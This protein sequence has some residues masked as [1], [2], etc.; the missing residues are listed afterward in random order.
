[1]N[2]T[3]VQKPSS[4]E[5]KNSSINSSTIHFLRSPLVDNIG[6]FSEEDSYGQEYF[7]I[8]TNIDLDKLLMAQPDFVAYLEEKYPLRYTSPATSLAHHLIPTIG[9]SSLQKIYL[10]KSKAKARECERIANS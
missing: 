4:L 9:H 10:N 2:F 1:M 7:G 8:D 5:R 3:R 6:V